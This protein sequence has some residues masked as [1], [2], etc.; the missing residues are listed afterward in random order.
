[1]AQPRSGWTDRPPGSRRRVHVAGTAPPAMLDPTPSAT[2][3]LAPASRCI[4][5]P[6]VR[7]CA[8]IEDD[9]NEAIRTAYLS[10]N[11]RSFQIVLLTF[12]YESTRHEGLA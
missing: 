9:S 11:H 8:I 4:L 7:S 3:S 1:M 5:R 12:S 6:G 10:R 2:S